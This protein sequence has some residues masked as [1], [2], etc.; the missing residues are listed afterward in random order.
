MK[1]LYDTLIEHHLSTVEEMLFLSGPRQVGKTT[2]CKL[3]N[4]YSNHFVYLNWDDSDHRS[5][6]L[7]GPQQIIESNQLDVLSEKKPIIVFDELHKY[8]DWKNFLKGFYDSYARQVAII[9]TG[10]ARLDIYKRGGDSLM[11]RYFPYR[12]HPLSVG[13]CLRT[14]LIETEIS[15]PTEIDKNIFEVLYEYGGF[16]KPFLMQNKQFSTRWQNLRKQQLLAEDIRDVNIVHDI[17]RLENLTNILQEQAS[18]SLSYSTIAKHL[19]VSNDTVT[20][21]IEILELFYFCFRI[22]P[23][24]KNISRSLIK[25]PKV[26]LYDWSVIKKSG[27]KAENFVAMHLLKAVQ[28]WS[29]RGFGEY[30]LYYLRTL[31][32]QEIDFI[33]TKN[34]NPWFI[35]EV[36]HANSG[37]I[38]PYLKYFQEQT[39]AKHAFQVII[40]MEYINKDCFSVETPIIVPAKTFLSQLV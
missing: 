23:W 8:N 24:S 29:D 3:A 33:V 18:S 31:D 30:D 4:E 26:Y 36:K 13:E 28:Y 35:V 2:S 15:S 19:R 14:N 22:R 38:S 16:P 5:T 12:M 6:I 17:H 27:A 10:S 32:K 37:H 21:W 39:K 9:V 40:D 1:R 25:E 7:R 11:G 20:R 34:G